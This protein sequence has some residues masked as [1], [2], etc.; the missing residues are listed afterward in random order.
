VETLAATLNACLQSAQHS[1]AWQLAGTGGV[2]NWLL[3][4]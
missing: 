1:E 2:L 4:L 3:G